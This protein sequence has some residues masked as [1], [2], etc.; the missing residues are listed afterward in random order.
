MSLLCPVSPASRRPR[1]RPAC[2]IAVLFIIR[3][4]LCARNAFRVLCWPL[5]SIRRRASPFPQARARPR[6]CSDSK[7]VA[8]SSGSRALFFEHTRPCSFGLASISPTI[9]SLATSRGYL[10][11]SPPVR[12]WLLPPLWLS[13]FVPSSMHD[14]C[15]ARGPFC[16][17]PY[18]WPQF[19]AASTDGL[20]I[21]RAP[22]LS[23][24]SQ[25]RRKA[26]QS[27]LISCST[28]HQG[29]CTQPGAR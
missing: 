19:L 9:L 25:R 24:R 4:T 10:P 13:F 21:E 28:E 11:A 2:P 17:L 22:R 23:R 29:G 20:I 12:L 7:R 26:D 3:S 15:G 27:R 1:A 14:L 18:S 5:A 6:R 16:L 8:A